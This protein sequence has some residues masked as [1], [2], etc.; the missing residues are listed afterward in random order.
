LRDAEFGREK[1]SIKAAEQA[2][3]LAPTRDVHILAAIALARAGRVDEAEGLANEVDKLN[4]LNTRVQHYWLPTARAAIYLQ[5]NEPQKAVEVLDRT[6]DYE[7]GMINPTIEVDGLLYPVF[8]RGEALLLLHREDEAVREFQKFSEHRTIV[9]NNPLGALAKLEIG[10][11]YAMQGDTVHARAAYQDF[12][13][14]WKDADANIPI[15]QKAKAEYA[16]LN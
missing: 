7:L 4:P 11:A 12:L 10:R 3:H 6:T 8:L 14:L 15:F 5:R 13:N 1:D 2:I 16:K 9:L